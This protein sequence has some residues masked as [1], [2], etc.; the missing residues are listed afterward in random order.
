MRTASWI[1]PMWHDSHRL[2]MIPTVC[3]RFQDQVM[4]WCRL[5]GLDPSRT[6]DI[7]LSPRLGCLA[8]YTYDLDEQ[9]HMFSVDGVSPAFHWVWGRLRMPPPAEWCLD[10]ET[11][12]PILDAE[13][14]TA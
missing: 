12:Q 4:A 3:F 1:D 7:I 5:H 10:Y 11:R 13:E 2:V 8:A 9:G 6:R 14:L